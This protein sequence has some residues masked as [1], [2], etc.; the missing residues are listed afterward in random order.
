MSKRLKRLKK[1]SDSQLEIFANEWNFDSFTY[2]RMKCLCPSSVCT[3]YAACDV[4]KRCQREPYAWHNIG[5]HIIWVQIHFN[6]WP[7]MIL[8]PRS[9]AH[10][11]FPSVTSIASIFLSF[12]TINQGTMLK[13]LDDP[14]DVNAIPLWMLTL[15]KFS[16]NPVYGVNPFLRLP[17]LASCFPIFENKN[18]VKIRNLTIQCLN[19]C[20]SICYSHP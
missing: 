12:S 2:C 4:T 8:N 13:G 14:N 7:W 16:Q 17:L 11:F 20:K 10:P 6:L 18:Y 15:S 5:T 1:I 19:Q 3:M 9:Q